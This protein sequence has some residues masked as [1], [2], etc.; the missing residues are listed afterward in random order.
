MATLS[1]TAA[2]SQFVGFTTL[3]GGL[4]SLAVSA[5]SI[6]V[7]GRRP[8]SSGFQQF[9]TVANNARTET[10]NSIGFNASTV[11]NDDSASGTATGPTWGTTND[12]GAF[13][14][15]HDTADTPDIT[16][17]LRNHTTDGAWAS[18]GA[19]TNGSPGYDAGDPASNGF[20]QLGRWLTSD[21]LNGQIA[22]VA[23]WNR[24]LSG[25]D[26]DE[27]V[28]NDRTS[29]IYN[30]STG[31]PLFL[32]ECNVAHASVIDLMNHATLDTPVSSPT[33]TGPDPE[34]WTF[35]SIG[36]APGKTYD[37]SLFP[38]FNMRTGGRI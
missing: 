30:L 21:Y 1:F 26:W 8:T 17:K 5:R 9:V 2:S 22:I 15:T 32:V 18:S 4:E 20:I 19:T 23:A 3:S 35:D 36:L 34:R 24:K 6:F 16:F 12:W 28:L 14:I 37:Y 29:D 13:G 31:A 25:A 7:L 11:I 33:L 38:K 27:I 10:F